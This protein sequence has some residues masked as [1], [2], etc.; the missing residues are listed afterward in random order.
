VPP[1]RRLLI[2]LVVFAALL[3]GAVGAVLGSGGDGDGPKERPP[4][5]S[6]G[7]E[8]S[9]TS[10]L[11]RIVPPAGEEAAGRNQPQAPAVPRSVA[12]LA[13]RLPLERKVAQLFLFGFEG[14]DLTAEIFRRL[15]RLDL[16]GI[17]LEER[18]YTG[19]PVL[20]QLGGEA[21]VIS[22]QAGHVPPWVLAIQEGGEHNSFAD[23]PPTLAP[24]DLASAGEAERQAQATAETLRGLN[25]T[26]VLGPVIDVGLETIPA[27][28]TRVYS[29]DPE[30]VAGYAEAVI[31]AYRRGRLFGAVSHFPGLGTAD[32]S[33]QTGPA[34]VGL[35]V[36]ELAERDLV[37]FRAAFDA[38]AAGVV[39]GHGLYPMTDFTEPAS[40]SRSVVTELLRER[41]NFAGV[42][43]TDDLADPAVTI[44]YPVP[45]AA[46]K[47]VKAGA[48]MIFISGPSGDQQAA[49]AA[50]LRAVRSG[51]IPRRRL[52][53]A[54][55]RVLKIKEGYG[56]IR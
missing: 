25:V 9:R 23:L 21:L 18:N 10:F 3:G 2:A 20:G 5:A 51:A 39:L 55:L 27:L 22:R 29:D 4:E 32:Q 56:L 30:E 45:K 16:G 36:E 37:P 48:D 43:I 49:Y 40:L 17:V 52:Q 54:L 33:T 50:V 26:G 13:R 6:R 47:A 12:D 19:A 15:R 28:G 24:A 42:A 53:E 1:R 11:A 8:R 7:D 14:T 38:G 46:V 35:D 41:L 34:T 31:D 44:A